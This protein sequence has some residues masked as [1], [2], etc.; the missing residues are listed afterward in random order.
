MHSMPYFKKNEFI[1]GVIT[2]PDMSGQRN[3]VKAF[4]DEKNIPVRQPA[5]LRDPEAIEWVD[6]LQPDLLVLAFVTDFVPK[7][8]ID[9]STRGGINYHPSLLPKYRGGSAMN[10]AIISGEMETGVTIHQIDEGVDTG[11]IILQEKVAIEPDDTLKSLYFKK[12]YPLGIKMIPEAVR[13]IR[14]G[15]AKP[16]P[17]NDSE[18]SYQPVINEKDVIINWETIHTDDLQSYPWFEPISWSHDVFNRRKAN[19]LGG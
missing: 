5:K 18:A 14:E 2:I 7:K 13:L 8:M 11:P 12:L 16:S 9:I 15:K 17:Q 19:N 1:V 10:W 3:P 6:N 4:A